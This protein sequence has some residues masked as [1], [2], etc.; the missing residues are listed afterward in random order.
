MKHILFFFILLSLY[1]CN[2]SK[3]NKTNT[4]YLIPETSQLI[5]KV[6]NFE[7]FKSDLKNNS[8]ITTLSNSEFNNNLNRAINNIDSLNINSELFICFENIANEVNYSIV[9]TLKDSIN[10]LKID[11]SL[12]L[13]IKDSIFIVSTSKT[14]I[15]NLKPN[16]S[17]LNRF[18]TVSSEDVSFSIFLT[19]EK[20]RL[21]GESL[22]KKDIATFSNWMALNVELSPDQILF[23]G[24]TFNNDSLPKLLGVFK[25]TIP[26]EN[27]IHK[28]TPI[29]SD[30][31]FSI[32]FENF[33]TLQQ[34]L[35]AYNTTSTDSIINNDLFLTIDEIGE[36]YINNQT[37]IIL[38]SID[39]ETTK[40]ALLEY[41]NIIST[42]RNVPILEFRNSELL[43]STFRPL[44]SDTSPSKYIMLD[45]FFVFSDSEKVLQQLI[46]NYQNGTVLSKS[47]RFKE[48]MFSLSDEASLLIFANSKRLEQI[49]ETIFNEDFKSSVFKDYGFNAF[50]FIND[51]G[52]I[53]IN[54]NI[55]KE[56]AR[57]IRKGVTEEFNVFI[58]NDIL[59]HPHFVINHRTKQKEIVVQDINNNLYL[60][61]N[62]GNVL[63]KKQLN[64]NILGRI[65]QVDLYKNGRLQLAFAT[66]NRIYLLDRNGK[67]VSP[68]PLRFNSKI[69]QPLSVFDY[70][71]K[72]E[73]RFLVTQSNSLLMYNKKGKLVNGFKYRPSGVIKTQP[74]HFRISNKDYIV[75]ATNNTMKVLNRQGNDRIIVRDVINFSG[76][77]IF[78]YNNRFTTTSSNGELIQVN[79]KGAVSKQSLN[80]E[81]NHF[82]ETTNKTLATLSENILTIKQ[83]SVE[84]DFG[85]YTSPKI[86]YLNDKIYI[87]VT[88]LQSKKIFLFDSQAKLL[89]NFPVYGNSKID[90]D[91]IDN[92]DALEFVVKG[93]SNSIILYKKN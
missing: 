27:T 28:I 79:T 36:V 41:Q 37:A 92:D 82:L 60:I 8:F 80:L 26:Q 49:S 40:D 70:D 93:D 59:M 31:F 72:R 48:M 14:I 84:L 87:T 91:N 50:Q 4:E 1:S 46:S 54:A 89:S 21:F 43:H 29:G 18:N 68:F 74:Q 35:I 53:H 33:Q 52:F 88:D 16:K 17:I 10:S 69:T 7:N 2:I 45:D 66:P 56:K 20:S 58:D 63:W 62:K 6:N 83:K 71:N 57:S 55:K 24:V 39:A 44:I 64:G 75:F 34:N 81:N 13:N 19:D 47:D 67:D 15:D 90:F 32:T 9:G 3:K 42:Y 5:L 61:S 38:K 73:Y 85:N 22:I 86:F 12:H 77:P 51:D 65:Q 25:Q 76:N 11:D 23:N 30:G 78:K